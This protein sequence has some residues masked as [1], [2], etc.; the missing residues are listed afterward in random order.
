MTLALVFAHAR[1]EEAPSLLWIAKQGYFLWLA[2]NIPAGPGKNK[3]DGYWDTD[4][5]SNTK[6]Q[7]SAPGRSAG[8]L[9]WPRRRR[10]RTATNFTGTP[11]RGARRL[12]AALFRAR[13]CGLHVEQ[14][15]PWAFLYQPTTKADNRPIRRLLVD[16]HVSP[17]GEIQL[18]RRSAATQ[19]PGNRKRRAN[20]NFD[21]F[22][23]LARCRRCE[24]RR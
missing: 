16:Q 22:F 20:P 19:W 11:E 7:G 8:E 2:A 18:M 4:L 21:Q 17:R 3:V 9:S 13:L 24:S 23:C 15:R 1:A 6:S 12:D 5:L 14:P 10:G